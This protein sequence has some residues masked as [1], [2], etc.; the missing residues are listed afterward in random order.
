MG[1]LFRKGEALQLLHETRVVAFDKTGTL[2]EGAPRMTDMEVV[3]GM[4]RNAVLAMIASVE[5]KSEHPISRAIVDAAKEANIDLPQ[6]S[7]FESL[8][9]MGVRAKVDGKQVCVGADRYMGALGLNV[10]R[11]AEAAGRLA[12]EGKT[13]LYA[14]IDDRLVAIIAVSDPIKESTPVSSPVLNQ[15]I[16][17]GRH[18]PSNL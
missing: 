1:V 7:N 12:T 15:L 5:A 18:C 13:P 11:F 3:E 9:G 17:T 14:A 10:E 6:A 4:D 2:T 16:C 8:T